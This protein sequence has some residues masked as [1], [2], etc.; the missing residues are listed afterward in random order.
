MAPLL[1]LASSRFIRNGSCDA[2]HAAAL[3]HFLALNRCCRGCVP[4]N[5]PG[6]GLS[7]L[8][9]ACTDD[10]TGEDTCVIYDGNFDSAPDTAVCH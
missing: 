9:I 2:D 5:C 1:V 6:G 3:L 4:L 7:N 8:V 10:T